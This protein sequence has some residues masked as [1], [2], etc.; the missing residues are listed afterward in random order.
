[1]S[2]EITTTE[3]TEATADQ[4]AP[5][6]KAGHEAAK[7][8]TRLR[9]TEAQ[10]D[11]LADQVTALRR[12]A[13]ED[14]L[15]SHRVPAAGFWAAGVELDEL[16]DDDGNLDDEKIKAA[17]DNAVESLGLERARVPAPYSPKEGNV[18]NPRP[19][20]SWEGAFGPQ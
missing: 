9:E 20:K 5:E 4:T 18:T 1:M 6:G 15:K 7:Y 13:V 12:A 10:R 19:S 16:M 17:A 11:Q 2:E 14:R 8:R 3:A